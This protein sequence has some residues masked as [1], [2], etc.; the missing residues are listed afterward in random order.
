MLASSPRKAA[1]ARAVSFVVSLLCGLSLIGP[2]AGCGL[3]SAPN[4]KVAHLPGRLALQEP[5]IYYGMSIN[6]F[7]LRLG[8]LQYYTT[9]DN[10]GGFRDIVL[11]RQVGD[12]TQNLRARFVQGRLVAF[13][14]TTS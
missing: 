1:S 2:L 7:R 10:G 11:R 9:A 12:V 6:E 5:G 3:P 8:H 14:H 13:G 4:S